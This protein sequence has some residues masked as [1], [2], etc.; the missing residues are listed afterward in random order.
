M[1]LLFQ[2]KLHVVV[3][4]QDFMFSCVTLVF[5]CFLLLYAIFD[6]Q[7][8]STK[9]LVERQGWK[10]RY[11]KLQQLGRFI[12]IMVGELVNK[13]GWVDDGDL[14]VCVCVCFLIFGKVVRLGFVY[15]SIG[16]V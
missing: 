13:Y 3:E 16:F 9:W 5:S 8:D 14:S 15:L 4:K 12:L 10:I 7:E 11:F 6:C 2:Q 1:Q